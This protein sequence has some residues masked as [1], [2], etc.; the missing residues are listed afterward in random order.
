MG[1]DQQCDHDP[2][3][4]RSLR[5][6]QARRPCVCEVLDPRPWPDAALGSV[7]TEPLLLTCSLLA[8]RCSREPDQRS[9]MP[10][11]KTCPM[12]PDGQAS[13]VLAGHVP[14]T[15]SRGSMPAITAT[16][17]GATPPPS[18]APPEPWD[19]ALSP[20]P[21]RP[22]AWARG[23]GPPFTLRAAKRRSGRLNR[24]MQ[25]AGC[26]EE[27]GG[28][29]FGRGR[30]ARAQGAPTTRPPGGGKWGQSR[31]MEEKTARRGTRSSPRSCDKRRVELGF[32]LWPA[33]L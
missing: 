30:A 11:C 7:V 18:L 22:G 13:Q 3:P 9:F 8:Q 24:R 27:D 1:S 6:L 17:V 26:V 23:M 25:T 19:G 29:A 12:G 31:L 21:H 15:R 20:R 32:E 10:S 2:F 5:D 33:T 16:R 28:S 4:A 14:V